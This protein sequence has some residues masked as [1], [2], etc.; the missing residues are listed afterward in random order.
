MEQ[1]VQFSPPAPR[2]RPYARVI[3]SPDGERT[4][5]A[6]LLLILFLLVL[7][8]NVAVVF[9]ELDAFRPALVV[10]IAALFMLAV[11]MGSSGLE[12][13]WN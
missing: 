2:I 7:Y 1:S 5:I 4:S 9:P 12:E 6:F 11:E 8:S 10:A 13:T 3:P